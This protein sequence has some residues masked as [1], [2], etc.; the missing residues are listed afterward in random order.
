[1]SEYN[2][3]RPQ[4][5]TVH[6]FSTALTQLISC[7]HATVPC[8]VYKRGNL[9]L[10]FL[11]G[12]DVGRRAVAVVV[13]RLRADGLATVVAAPTDP[14]ATHVGRDAGAVV[15]AAC[16]GAVCGDVVKLATRK[17]STDKQNSGEVKKHGC[18]CRPVQPIVHTDDG[19]SGKSP[20][21]DNVRECQ[22][23]HACCEA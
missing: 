23:H 9:A 8:R 17:H 1:M 14:A 2:R 20:G 10:T 5:P 21:K 6:R 18:S 15:C 16:N 19:H 13:T 3:S 11:A 22:H 12:A 4:N 7:D